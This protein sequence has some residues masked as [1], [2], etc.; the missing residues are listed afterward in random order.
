MLILSLAGFHNEKGTLEIP[1]YPSTISPHLFGYD[2]TSY[3]VS[4][5]PDIKHNDGKS[6]MTWL[7]EILG[8]DVAFKDPGGTSMYMSIQ[9]KTV[10][11]VIDF[12]QWDLTGK[13][14]RLNGK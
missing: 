6:L 4:K 10:A 13:P 3:D 2:H 8:K 14:A 7:S 9:L 12:F 1:P 11:Q 5:I